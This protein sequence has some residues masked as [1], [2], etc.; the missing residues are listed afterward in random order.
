MTSLS[1][2]IMHATAIK[3]NGKIDEISSIAG[4]AKE[5]T[6]EIM[7][8]VV[9]SGRLVQIHDTYMLSPAGRMILD[10]EYSRFCYE[11]R[12]D[13]EFVNSYSE[14]ETINRNLKQL[15]TEWQTVEV[16]GQVIP[17]DHSD[18]IY[19]EGIVDRLGTIHEQ[20]E[21]IL[22][23]MIHRLERFK[24]Y[25]SKLINALEKA[26]DGDIDWVSDARIES[27]HTVWFELHEDLLRLLGQT[28]E[29]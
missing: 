7:E 14:F 28:R 15:I 10:S 29:D 2:L 13:E 6:V 20:F 3:R 8:K 18:S 21:P 19:D 22:N 5:T 27:Y 11:I 16:G 24:H 26:E 9:S 4:L 23:R 1:H 12:A 25:Q 17:N